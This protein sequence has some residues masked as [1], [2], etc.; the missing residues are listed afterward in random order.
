MFPSITSLFVSDNL[1]SIWPSE[2]ALLPALVWLDLSNN[3][4]QSI[5]G[6]SRLPQLRQ[7]YLTNNQICNLPAEMSKCTALHHLCLDGNILLPSCFGVE[8]AGLEQ[9]QAQIQEISR[10]YGR[11]Q[12][13]RNAMWETVLVFNVKRFEWQMPLEILH[14]FILPMIWNTRHDSTW[15][16]V[17]EIENDE[18]LL[19]A[20]VEDVSARWG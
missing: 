8:T 13:T 9:V 4:L 16:P 14:H 17:E 2:L 6:V 3:A 18:E 20:Q 11:L 5:E 7:L 10:F 1:I 19:E 12:A 15:D